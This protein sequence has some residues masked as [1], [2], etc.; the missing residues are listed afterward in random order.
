MTDS[1]SSVSSGSSAC[2]VG[3]SSVL[4]LV[5]TVGGASVGGGDGPG[6]G[7]GVGPLEGASVA[8]VCSQQDMPTS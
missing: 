7:G 3:S 4:P 6:V 1:E 5:L 2:V 8:D